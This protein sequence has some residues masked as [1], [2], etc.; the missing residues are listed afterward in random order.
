MKTLLP[1]LLSAILASG[2]SFVCASDTV[3]LGVVDED[4]SH[5]EDPHERWRAYDLQDYQIDQTWGCFCAPP[6]AWTAVIR[7]GEVVDVVVEPIQGMDPDEVHARALELAW[8]VEDAFDQI[9]SVPGG[10]GMGN[11]P[12]PAEFQVTYHSRFGYPESVYI[13]WHRGIADDEL[14]TR[15]DNLRYP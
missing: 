15:L 12:G 10:R 5:I 3:I 2:G 14:H 9:G 13:D 11:G 7:N 8:T 1:A 6:H 4:F